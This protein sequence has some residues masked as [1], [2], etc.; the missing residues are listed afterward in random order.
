MN[1]MRSSLLPTAIVCPSFDHVILIFSPFVL[2]VLIGL[3]VLVSQIRTVRSP[4]AVANKSGFE[5]KEMFG[6]GNEIL[7]NL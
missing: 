2:I 6:L 5:A 3:Y 7:I 4:E 1:V